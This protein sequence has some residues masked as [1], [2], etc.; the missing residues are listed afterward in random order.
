MLELNQQSTVRAKLSYCQ[1]KA[2]VQAFSQSSCVILIS[3]GQLPHESKKLEATLKVIN[4]NFASC[5]V[6]VCDSLQRHSLQLG[7]N[8][9]DMEAY[10]LSNKL[11]EEWIERNKIALESISIS[12]D[13]FRWDEWLN[14]EDYQKYQDIIQDSYAN[15]LEFKSAMDITVE[16][17][18]S[19]FQKRQQIPLDVQTIKSASLKYLIEECA[20]IM[21]M[22]QSRKYNYIIYPGTIL[23]VLDKTH[24]KFVLPNHANLLNWIKVDFKTK[25]VSN[26]QQRVEA[27]V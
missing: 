26:I 12:Y 15:D 4:D 27:T 11:G 17:F 13:V 18:T 23:P 7:T 20:I 16:N 10:N 22:W 1:D 19:R 2:V 6:A 21:L 3:V 14:K 25:K 5:A 9:S 24:K 8:L